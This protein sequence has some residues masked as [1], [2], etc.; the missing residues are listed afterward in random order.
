MKKMKLLLAATMCAGVA[1][2]ATAC[3]KKKI[4]L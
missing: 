3:G 2:S 4:R 1:F